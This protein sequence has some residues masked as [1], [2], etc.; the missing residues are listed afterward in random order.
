MCPREMSDNKNN[1]ESLNKKHV[2]TRNDT[3]VIVGRFILVTT[4]K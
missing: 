1:I 2:N 4:P 3:N